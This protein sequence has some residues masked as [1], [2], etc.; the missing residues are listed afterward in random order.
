MAKTTAHQRLIFKVKKTHTDCYLDPEIHIFVKIFEFYL[1]TPVPLSVSV[2][3]T[4]CGCNP[5]CAWVCQSWGRCPREECPVRGSPRLW[6]AGWSGTWTWTCSG[7]PAACSATSVRSGEWRGNLQTLIQLLQGSITPVL[8]YSETQIRKAI[9]NCAAWHKGCGVAQI[10]ARWL[11][12][13]QA[14]VRISARHPRGG[15]ILSG[16]D[17]DNKKRFSTSYIYKYCILA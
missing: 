10:V 13:R 2:S 14:R 5:C 8:S 16:S 4:T 17:E 15:P 9:Q 7:S 1:V 6:P 11:A 3:N 12:V